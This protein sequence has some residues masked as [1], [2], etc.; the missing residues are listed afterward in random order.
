MSHLLGKAKL[1][2]PSLGSS[3]TASTLTAGPESASGGVVSVRV[4]AVLATEA[5]VPADD[6]STAG[7]DSPAATDDGDGASVE[8]GNH[9]W[10][11]AATRPNTAMTPPTPAHHDFECHLVCAISGGC[12]GA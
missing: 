4:D 11:N 10:P 2:A 3:R 9:H 5:P 7:K 12:D 1:R 6:A 8:R